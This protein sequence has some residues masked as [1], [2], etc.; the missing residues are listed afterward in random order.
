MGNRRLSMILIF[1]LV[2]MRAIGQDDQKYARLLNTSIADYKDMFTEMS[3]VDLNVKFDIPYFNY[4]YTGN[5]KLWFLGYPIN[6]F[7]L[8]V[9]DENNIL[10]TMLEFGDNGSKVLSDVLEYFGTPDRVSIMERG[11]LKRPISL[12]RNESIEYY[13]KHGQ[14]N[15]I[16]FTWDA[17]TSRAYG[18]FLEYHTTGTGCY[19]K[20][21]GILRLHYKLP[22]NQHRNFMVPLTVYSEH[23]VQKKLSDE[24]YNKLVAFIVSQDTAISVLHQRKVKS[25]VKK[26]KMTKTDSIR[27]YRA[28]RDKRLVLIKKKANFIA[29]EYL[30]KDLKGHNF[31]EKHLHLSA[32]QTQAIIERLQV[33]DN[34]N[35]ALISKR[36]D[37]FEKVP[38]WQGYYQISSAV[39]IDEENY[40]IFY[41][42]HNGHFSWESV[43]VTFTVAEGK[44]KVKNKTKLDMVTLDY[45]K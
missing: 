41:Y 14:E 34:H 10:W 1:I 44:F 33:D 31:I 45:P 6:D 25:L 12:N 22:N 30:A 17:T 37:I 4:L 24:I 42:R 20:K 40:F 11:K 5:E 39:P 27:Y 19:T 43:A 2:I 28:I 21:T 36:I 23:P 38:E 32:M 18:M 16:G 9:S 15:C 3:Y 8:G 29:R 7:A 13:Y 35:P 26:G